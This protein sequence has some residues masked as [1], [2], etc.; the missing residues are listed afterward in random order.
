MPLLEEN[1]SAIELRE[2][3][4]ELVRRL[5][6][7]R[8]GINLG[9]NR[10]HLVQARLAKRIRVEKLSGFREY[11]RLLESSEGEA[12][13]VH[14]IDAISTNTTFFFRESDHFDFLAQTLNQRIWDEHWDQRSYDV[15]IWSAACSSGEE[16]YC[17][18]MVTQRVLKEYPQINFKILATDISQKIL[19]QARQGIYD[20]QK[21]R[22]IP[23]LYRHESVRPIDKNKSGMYEIVPEL[24]KHIT[25]APFNLISPNYPFRHGFD[26]VFCR[27]VMI[28]FDRDTQEQV[29]NR[30][31]PHVRPGG[32][33]IVGHSESLSA[34]KHN[35]KGVLPSIYKQR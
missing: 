35:F 19:H 9:S 11:F 30:I 32:Y 23:D 15:R 5:V 2:T 29:I 26:F 3:E 33:L 25:F 4:Y 6:Y 27:N 18:A 21:I 20:F 16:P 12:E 34:I 14:L 17:L 31:G 22:T 8:S 7:E 13:I 24:R 10:Q 1:F 28:Y